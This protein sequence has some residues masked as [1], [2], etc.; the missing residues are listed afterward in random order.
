MY[1]FLIV[2]CY[3][4]LGALLLTP[5]LAMRVSMDAMLPGESLGREQILPPAQ[6]AALLARLMM[7]K[8]EIR[9][10]VCGRRDADYC[11]AGLC[12]AIPRPR[13]CAEGTSLSRL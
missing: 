5:H 8:D 3:A 4:I 10:E 9:G 2:G 6:A 12:V 7:V 11:L 13:S 1:R